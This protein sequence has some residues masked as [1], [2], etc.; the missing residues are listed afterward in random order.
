MKKD[1]FRSKSYEDTK[2]GC[3]LWHG[4]SPRGPTRKAYEAFKGPIPEG[5]W[6]LHTCDVPKCINPQHL[7]LGDRRDNM[8]DA[9][10]KRRQFNASKTHCPKGHEYTKANIYLEK[11]GSG[12]LCRKC[13]VC[14]YEKVKRQ[15]AKNTSIHNRG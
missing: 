2:T 15:R 4:K 7:W 14:A 9:V 8:V 11:N 6:V 3:W 13:K 10:S 1:E 5:L 12:F